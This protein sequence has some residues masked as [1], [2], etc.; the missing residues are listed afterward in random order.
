MQRCH[1]RVSFMFCQIFSK[2]E[3]GFKIRKQ[4]VR[5][6]LLESDLKLKFDLERVFRI[7][8]YVFKFGFAGRLMEEI[9]SGDNFLKT[10][11]RLLKNQ[12]AFE[13]NTLPHLKR[14]L[15]ECEYCTSKFG[16]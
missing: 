9:G 3:F 8:A 11:R 1:F 16:K 12:N 6:L 5:V 15:T 2:A 10:F 13:K 4:H 7:R 14:R